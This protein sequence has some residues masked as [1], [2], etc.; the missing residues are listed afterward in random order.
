MQ[1]STKK[2]LAASLVAALVV[3]FAPQASS[4]TTTIN[5]WYWK[6]NPSSTV[7]RDLAVKFEAKTGIHVNISDDVTS[8]NYFNNLTNAIAAGNAPD[9]TELNTPQL[10][11]L[12]KANALAPLNA[13]IKTWSKSSDVTSSLWKWVKSADGKTTYALPWK[14]LMFLMLYRKDTFAA[15]GIKVPTTQKEFLAAAAKLYKPDKGQYAFNLRGANGSD[16]W[17]SFMVA[18]GAKFTNISGDIAFDSQLT[19][20]ANNI[21]I[22]SYKYAPPSTITSNSGTALVNELEAGVTAMVINHIAGARALKNPAN[23]GFAPIPSRKGVDARTTYMGTMNMNAI[24]NTSKQK[25]AAFKWISYLAENEAQL[26]VAQSKEGFLPVTNT[27]AA[28]PSF[29]DDAAFQLSAQLAQHPTLA[30]PTVPGTT[31]VATTAWAPA[32]QSALLGKSTSDDMVRA[33]AAALA[34]R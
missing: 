25:D 19:R 16:Q 2:W 27:V 21:Y 7:V 5:Y 15:A 28:D 12:L 10:P 33:V 13:N 6:E 26:A 17:A 24:L 4:A 11:Q 3:G 22:S 8:A 31:I 9:A 20:D 14:Y 23:V 18:G 34:Q 29:K 30:W 32:M 1:K